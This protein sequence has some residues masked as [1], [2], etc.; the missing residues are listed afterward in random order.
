MALKVI[1][2]QEGNG[3]ALCLDVWKW[4]VVC[5]KANFPRVAYVTVLS[6]NGSSSVFVQRS[7]YDGRVSRAAR[8]RHVLVLSLRTSTRLS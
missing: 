2:Y 3:G 1:G 6:E 7:I 8:V 5:G 4:M